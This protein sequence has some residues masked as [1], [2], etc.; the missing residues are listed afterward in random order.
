[1]TMAPDC[2]SVPDNAKV[3]QTKAA[4]LLGLSTRTIRRRI[5]DGTFRAERSG[6]RWCVSGR[7][8]KDYWY[9]H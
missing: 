9:S 6:K 1:M 7:Q 2:P 5:L 4:R 3:C 8:I